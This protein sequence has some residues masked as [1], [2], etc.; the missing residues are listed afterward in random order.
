MTTSDRCSQCGQPLPPTGLCPACAADFLQGDPTAAPGRAFVPPSVEEL[1]GHFP[2]LEILGLIGNGGMG[3]VY[4][5]RQREL[6]R[7]VALKILP[8]GIGDDPAFASRFAREA[9]ALAKLSHPN[10]VTLYEFGRGAG[11]GPY[12]FLMEYVDGVNLRQLLHAERVAPREALE[13]VPQICDALQYAHDQGIVHRDIKPE[14]IL[15]DRRG[16]VKVADFGLAKIIGAATAESE[17]SG[18]AAAEAGA[19]DAGKIMGT[20]SYMAP[21]QVERP[22]EVD[23]RA[24]I[25]ALG[26]VFYQMLTG[27]LPGKSLEPPSRKVRIDVRLDEVVLRALEKNPELRYSQASVLKTQVETI[28]ETPPPLPREASTEGAAPYAW[29]RE[30][31]WIGSGTLILLVCFFLSLGFAVAYPRQAAAPILMVGLLTFGLVAAA[32]RWAGVWPFPTLLFSG[33]TFSSRNL[34]R[35]GGDPAQGAAQDAWRR[36]KIILSLGAFLFLVCFGFSLT[37][38]L[39]YGRLAIV[40]IAIMGFGLTV[41]LVRLA[42]KWPFPSVWFRGKTFSSRNIGGGAQTQ[43]DEKVKSKETPARIAAGYLAVGCGLLSLFLPFALAFEKVVV[44]WLNE[45][46]WDVLLACAPLLGLLAVGLGFFARRLRSGFSGL[47]L[48]GLCLALWLVLFF[49]A[50]TGL[51]GAKWFAHKP[52]QTASIEPPKLQYL[53]WLDQVRGSSPDWSCWRPDGELVPRAD[54]H[55]PAGISVPSGTPSPGADPRFVC[56]WISDPSFDAQSVAKVALLDSDG[57]PLNVPSKDYSIGVSA[58]SPDSP[59][60]GWISATLCAGSAGKTPTFITVSLKYS[61]GP[62]TYWDNVPAD[63][64][65]S[66]AVDSG[67]HVLDPGQGDDGKAYIGVTRQEGRDTGME[68]FDFVAVT[69]DGRELNRIGLM[70]SAS[71]GVRTERCTFDVPLDQVRVFRCRKRPIQSMTWS[72]VALQEP[73]TFAPVVE[74][75][76]PE[77][78]M[79]DFDTGKEMNEIPK[80]IQAESDIA[81]TILD[82]VAWMEGQGLDVINDTGHSIKAVDLKIRAL[83]ANAWDTLTPEDLRA[84]LANVTATQWSDLL[85]NGKLPATYAFQTRQGGSGILQ[86]TGTTDNP[87]AVKIRYKMLREQVVDPKAAALQAVQSW[88]GIMDDGQ[89]AQAWEQAAPSFQ[90]AGTQDDWVQKSKD[91]RAPLGKVV[92]R[93]VASQ[94]STTKLPGMPD[95]TYFVAEFHTQFEGLPSAKE[96]VAMAQDSSGAWQAVAYLIL[97]DEKNVPGVT[98][99]PKTDDERAAVSAAQAWLAAID[100]GKYSESWSEAEPNFRSAVSQTEWVL[101]L[102]AARAPLGALRSRTLKSVQSC[103]SLP[104]A[105]DGDYVVMQFNTSFANKVSAIETVTF[106]RTKDGK[107]EASGYFIK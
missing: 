73:A 96:Q 23:H 39:N 6:D 46:V 49:M 9:R 26:V 33:K 101:D 54:R 19:T 21:E 98:A 65:G 85:P 66:M 62:W 40:P 82:A 75:T 97:P 38:A 100:A 22:A 17:T 13:I 52:S 89:Y 64:S 10:I 72:N 37:F 4:K 43:S 28:A 5:A 70:E 60:L 67:V 77:N 80:S 34:N 20:P 106:A 103:K 25:Y 105:P 2:Q 45:S 68:Q 15:I 74:R 95:G 18:S 30:K 27:E 11:D 79:L 71:G 57:K 83:D 42:G 87:S 99:T 56:L 41:C 48:G 93:K 94:V 91:I 55:I 88:L 12:F 29:H 59:N 61:G 104:G 90:K 1:A 16:R 86:I 107:W 3:A 14:N 76:L 24:D 81:K 32:L 102:T 78:E 63:F 58:P 35:E 36:E 47:V 92:S 51:S 31:L 84:S 69:K 8:P 53:A 44:G 50:Q 7:I